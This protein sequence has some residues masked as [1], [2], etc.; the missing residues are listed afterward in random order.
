M[1]PWLVNQFMNGCMME[2]KADAGNI[3]ARL[4]LNVVGWSV[5][6]FL[7]AN[8]IVLLTENKGSSKSSR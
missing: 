5:V 4:K 1:L 8:D 7:S 3:S 6:V 2:M